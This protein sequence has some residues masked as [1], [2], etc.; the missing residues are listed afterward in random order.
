[1]KST[2]ISVTLK[3]IRP[4]MFDR[5]VSMKTEL[6]PEDKVYQK[7]GNLML[8]AKNIMSFL[9]A[10]NTESAPKRIMGK[11]WRTICKAAMSFVDIGPLDILFDRNGNPISSGDVEIVYDKAIV[12]KG[13][14]SIPSEK[15]RPLLSLPWALSFKI[16][17]FQ[18]A[19]LNEATLRRLF[20]E[21]GIMIG[22][23][24]YRGVYGKFIVERWSV[25]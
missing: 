12:K 13:T 14:L 1:M 22:L 16:E 4:I 8:P 9:S 5:F 23:G 20:E 19:D 15:Q 7:D 17:L 24:T 11:K 3:G 21:G 6:S 25:E 18:N 10:E 2:K